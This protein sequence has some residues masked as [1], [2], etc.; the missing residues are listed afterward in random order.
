[1]PGLGPNCCCYPVYPVPSCCS[2]KTVDRWEIEAVDFTPT[3][4]CESFEGTYIPNPIH[5]FN[6]CYPREI[7]TFPEPN[8]CE[9]LCRTVI[10]GPDGA[11]FYISLDEIEI[12][13]LVRST[14]SIIGL[15]SNVVAR[16]W[17]TIKWYVDRR[18]PITDVCEISAYTQSFIGDAENCET[19]EFTFN[20]NEVFW[21]GLKLVNSCTDSEPYPLFRLRTVLV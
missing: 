5:A 13:T 9:A 12:S 10:N 11:D 18:N 6:E 15:P 17:L 7:I 8:P 21:E 2:S 20:P 19:F 3:N 1:M 14:E 16:T 4:C